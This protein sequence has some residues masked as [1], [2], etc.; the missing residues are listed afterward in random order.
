LPSIALPRNHVVIL[1]LTYDLTL[2]ASEEAL[3][4]QVPIGSLKQNTENVGGLDE[5]LRTIETEVK[6]RVAALVP[7]DTTNQALFGHSLGG[8]LAVLHALFVEPNAFRTFIIASPSI[9]WNNRAVLGD[10]AKFAGDVSSGRASPR[11][12]VTI[13]SEESTAPKVVPASWGINRDDLV[14]SLRKSAMVENAA[15]LVRR[16]KAFPGGPGYRVADFA[17]FDKESHAISPWSALARGISFAFGDTDV[18]EK[19]LLGKDDMKRSR[20]RCRRS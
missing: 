19:C 7:I 15:A 4:N 9:W 5:F 6:P 2:P 13:G 20:E 1:A 10:E 16:L 18:S 3:A 17:L 8:G 11:V 12:L 14:E